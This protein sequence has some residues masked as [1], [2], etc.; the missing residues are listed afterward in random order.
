MQWGTGVS[1]WV[2]P[3]VGAQDPESSI[4]HSMRW[5]P[6]IRVMRRIKFALAASFTRDGNT[7]SIV[8]T[9]HK[10]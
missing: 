8:T 6:R 2:L 5:L 3:A 7:V 1:L 4:G 9:R 10:Y